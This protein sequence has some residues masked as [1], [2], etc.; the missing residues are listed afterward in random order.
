M[1]RAGPGP[2]GGTSLLGSLSTVTAA[3]TRLDREL[4]AAGRTGPLTA[5][6]PEPQPSGGPGPAR[7]RRGAE[8]TDIISWEVPLAQARASCSCS[9][10]A[11]QTVSVLAATVALRRGSR[12][13]QLDPA[14][15]TRQPVPGRGLLPQSNFVTLN[16]GISK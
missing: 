13:S 8:N 3:V 6:Q 5:G 15:V 12:L 9:L 2:S 7:Q 4:S 16:G 14:A 10:C 11:L 1:T